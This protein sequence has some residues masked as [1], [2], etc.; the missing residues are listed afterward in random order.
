[1]S[2]HRPRSEINDLHAVKGPEK[3]CMLKV[4]HKFMD[5]LK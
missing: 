5:W 1:V 2:G 3:V 4:G